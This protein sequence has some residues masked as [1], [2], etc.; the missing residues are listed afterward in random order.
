MRRTEPNWAPAEALIPD[1]L[2]DLMW[3]GTVHYGE[4]V[5]EQ[6]KHVDLRSYINLDPSG[7]AWQVRVSEGGEIGARRIDLLTARLAVGG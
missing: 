4:A 6:Y 3:M 7:Q 1:L 5:I 2:P